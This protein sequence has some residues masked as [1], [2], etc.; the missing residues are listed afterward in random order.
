ML[1]PSVIGVLL[2]LSVFLIGSGRL[3]NGLQAAGSIIP[4]DS[5]SARS[6]KSRNK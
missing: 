2:A 4:S 6:M 1:R 3:R 5:T